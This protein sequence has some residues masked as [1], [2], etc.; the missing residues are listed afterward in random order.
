MC[1]SKEVRGARENVPAPSSSKGESSSS[2]GQDEDRKS[3]DGDRVDAV[4]TN[5]VADQPFAQSVAPSMEAPP[6]RYCTTCTERE[7]NR[8]VAIR[9][10][11][12]K[13]PGES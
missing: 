1:G 3:A 7:G 10:V 13:R 4:G 2:T 9:G 5:R 6:H 11:V 12:A 8:S